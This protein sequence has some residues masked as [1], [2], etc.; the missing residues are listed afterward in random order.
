MNQQTHLCACIF[1]SLETHWGDAVSK[2]LSVKMRTHPFCYQNNLRTALDSGWVSVCLPVCLYH[3]STYVWLLLGYPPLVVIHSLVC[4]F[5]PCC[6]DACPDLKCHSSLVSVF[7]FSERKVKNI[8][9]SSQPPNVIQ[10]FSLTGIV[11][12]ALS[13][14]TMRPDHYCAAPEL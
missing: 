5:H 4:F 3:F 9:C 7:H 13:N 8:Y 11:W 12:S 1:T 14:K 10:S 2:P 6:Q